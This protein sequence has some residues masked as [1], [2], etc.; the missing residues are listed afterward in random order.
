[1]YGSVPRS[2]F[3][4]FT[5]RPSPPNSKRPAQENQTNDLTNDS[6][7]LSDIELTKTCIEKLREGIPVFKTGETSNV[8]DEQQRGLFT[9]VSRG[10]KC[11]SSELCY[12]CQTQCAPAYMSCCYVPSDDSAAECQYKIDKSFE[13]ENY[14]YLVCCCKCLKDVIAEKG[15]ATTLVPLPVR[16][17]QNHGN[18]NNNVNGNPQTDDANWNPNAVVHQ[19]SATGPTDYFDEGKQVKA[20]NEKQNMNADESQKESVDGHLNSTEENQVKDLDGDSKADGEGSH[21]TFVDDAVTKVSNSYTIMMEITGVL[22]KNMYHYAAAFKTRTVH[23]TRDSELRSEWQQ[24]AMVLDRMM[25]F[26]FLAGSA[27]VLSRLYLRLDFN[28]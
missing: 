10:E 16:H 2:C 20:T 9:V 17:Q 23:E 1:M 11:A 24:A 15:W 22:L 27:F 5:I 6:N 18:Q 13:D 19:N 21:V 3:V 7:N 8:A 25:F 28:N 14:D 26:V 4:D 12:N